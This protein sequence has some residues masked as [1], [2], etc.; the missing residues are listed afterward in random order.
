MQQSTN[1][2][3]GP[4]L[5]HTGRQNARKPSNERERKRNGRGK[6][7]G[8]NGHGRVSAGQKSEATLRRHK[9]SEHRQWVEEATESPDGIWKIANWAKSRPT[10]RVSRFLLPLP[11][12][13]RTVTDI[14]DK[15]KFF[16]DSFFPT[17][18]QPKLDDI[19]M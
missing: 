5:R 1:R 11:V 9:A 16:H 8:P 17:L 7:G 3:H 12:E 10:Q 4:R 6:D 19:N 18:P 13:D 14:E 15:I 2:L